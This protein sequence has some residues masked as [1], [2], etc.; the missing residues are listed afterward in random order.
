MLRLYETR[1]GQ[2]VGV[3]PGPLKLYVRE[4]DDLR[5]CLI[6]D[7]LRRLASR[8]HRQSLTTAAHDADHGPW[9][10][11][12]LYAGEPLTG[13]LSVGNVTSGADVTVASW[14]PPVTEPDDPLTLRLAL[15]T[16]HYREEAVI[17]PE[18]VSAC[19]AR[20]EVWRAEVARWGT[21]PSRAIDK[22]TA[23]AFLEAV[24][25]DLD[26]AAGLDVLDALAGSELEPGAKFETAVH[27]DLVLGLDLV[28]LLGTV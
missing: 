26:I 21:H 13:A 27:L 10:I 9:N 8:L 28:R 15:L 24:G 25:E 7:V 5:V 4:P 2:V 3:R 18:T 1:T 22:P 12:P 17:G 19:A 23:E 16:V 14:A 11:P 6:A 20:I